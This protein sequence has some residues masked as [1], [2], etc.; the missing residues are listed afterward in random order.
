MNNSNLFRLLAFFVFV[1]MVFSCK[2]ESPPSVL[3]DTRSP[4]IFFSSPVL[5]PFGSA[6]NISNGTYLP[7]D[8]RFEDDV[9]LSD[10]QIRI[11]IMREFPYLKTEFDSWSPTFVGFLSGMADGFNTPLY[12]ADD[13]IAGYYEF[14]VTVR[15]KAGKSTMLS[16][17]FYL[18]N[19]SDTVP[20]VITISN[21]DPL[22]RTT[23]NLGSGINIIGNVSDNITLDD[24][25]VRIKNELTKE[26][27]PSSF[28]IDT[29]YFANYSI[30]TTLFLDPP[31]TPGN[32]LIEVIAKDWVQ[33]YAIK[34]APITVQ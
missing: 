12:V 6:T 21:P 15:D 31:L 29:L 23:H 20:P 19:Q 18:Q 34:T 16:T 9:E 11:F 8:I 30:N 13:P 28:F 25:T 10:Y 14:E 7:I 27:L 22:N 4:E 26:I 17:Y 5:V 33:N 24:V 32:Y 3:E 1:S 2:K